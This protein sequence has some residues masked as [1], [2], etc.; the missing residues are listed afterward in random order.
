MKTIKPIGKVAAPPRLRLK[1][2]TVSDVRVELGRLYRS[3]KV[4]TIAIP[5]ASKL[6]NILLILSRI[7]EGSSLEQRVELLEANRDA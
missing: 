4:G 2:S 7:I 5:D 1:L 3:A 6:A